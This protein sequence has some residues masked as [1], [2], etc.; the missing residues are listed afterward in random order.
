MKREVA[1]IGILLVVAICALTACAAKGRAS[2]LEDT[3]WIV[4]SL[5]PKDG[6]T[7]VLESNVTGAASAQF[8]SAEGKV[9]G[10]T[11]CNRFLASYSLKDDTLAISTV[12]ATEMFC[13]DPEGVMQQERL[14]LELLASAE[15]YEIQDDRL[16]ITCADGQVIN[17]RAQEE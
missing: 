11:G 3:K 8:D 5:G 16:T 1:L 10:A 17:F 13:A 12:A 6:P 9:T 2:A 4:E 14:Y 15:T 7:A